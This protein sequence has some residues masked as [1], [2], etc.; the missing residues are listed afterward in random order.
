MTQTLV[1]TGAGGFVGAHLCR[2]AAEAGFS[3]FAIG[4][5][6]PIPD[7]LD[8]IVDDYV[9]ADLT[10][11]WPSQAPTDADVVHLAGLAAV[12][13]SFNRPQLYLSANS[14]MVTHLAEALLRGSGGGRIVGVSSGA[15]Y[16]TGPGDSYIDEAA[17]VGF[18]SPYAVSKVLVENQLAY[19]RGRGLDT[20]V[21]RPFNHSGPGQGPGFLIPDLIRRITESSSGDVMSVGSLSTRRDYTDVRD[22]A[23]AYLSLITAPSVSHDIYNVASGTTRSGREI[24]A[25]VSAAL[26]HPV[27]ETRVDPSL[28]RPNDPASITGDAR[29]LR[30][31]TGWAPV[32]AFEQMIADSV[33]SVTA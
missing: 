1:V 27:P 25:A 4:R 19:Y 32:I 22:V 29:R 23:R 30:A 31:E 8:G 3:V 2:I 24:L 13:A 28:V 21:A 15:V 6:S 16:A 33:A 12:G 7:S 26:G 20:V 10:E 14:A 17:S 11:E 18:S 5:D 9:G